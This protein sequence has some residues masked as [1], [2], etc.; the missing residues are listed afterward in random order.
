M[1]YPLTQ[2]DF[3]DHAQGTNRDK[4]VRATVWGLLVK[5]DDESYYVLSWGCDN[6]IDSE[7]SD[8]YIILK[9]AV[10][11]MET[12]CEIEWPY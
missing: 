8:V 2:I 11:D 6:D 10:V 4:A 3:L 7:N 9:C 1:K 12:V 5:E